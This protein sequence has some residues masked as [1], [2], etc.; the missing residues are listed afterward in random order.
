M[1]HL[2]QPRKWPKL[3]LSRWQVI[4]LSMLTVLIAAMAFWKFQ[5]E[6]ILPKSIPVQMM[7]KETGVLDDQSIAKTTVSPIKTVKAHF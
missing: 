1:N 4:Q 6:Q 2:T 3:E 7:F 5:Y